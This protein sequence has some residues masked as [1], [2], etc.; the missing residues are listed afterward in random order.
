MNYRT[1]GRTG[2][3]VSELAFGT[4]PILKG[5][6]SYDEIMPKFFS[7]STEE[8]VKILR[9]AFEK[10]INHYDTATCNEYGDAEHKVG[11]AFQGHALRKDVVIASRARQ[12]SYEGMCNA[13][14]TSLKALKTDYIDIFYIHQVN[15]DNIDTALN[16]QDGAIKALRQH[17]QKGNI[18]FIGMASHHVDVFKQALLL[19]DID[20]Y[21]FPQNIVE[22]GFYPRI[23]H[24][25]ETSNIGTV[26]MKIFGAGPLADLYDHALLI[27]YP[28]H[29]LEVHSALIGIGT[30][31]QLVENLDSY[32]RSIYER[33][34]F[35]SQSGQVI[36]NL[37]QQGHCNRCQLCICPLG[38]KVSHILRYRAYHHFYGLPS[39]STSRYQDVKIKADQCT[40]CGICEQQCPLNLP[41]IKMLKDAHSTL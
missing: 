32:E 26:A 36:S 28:L 22:N 3:K 15:P 5:F 37:A 7:P 8:A 1:L 10:G 24:D 4:I 39:F 17:K 13:V 31:E 33:D 21:Q 38:M 9:T 6:K 14:E 11:V 23:R 2:L 16:E 25:V 20:V 12:Y 35:K 41:I 30:M 27:S 19:K 40:E 18:R 29:E 34:F